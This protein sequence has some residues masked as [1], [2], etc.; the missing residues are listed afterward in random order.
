MKVS[1]L[2]TRLAP[3]MVVA[4]AAGAQG[5][6]A[7]AWPSYSVKLLPAIKTATGATQ[8]THA[9]ALSPS[10][11]A[12]G[13]TVKSA[14]TMRIPKVYESGVGLFPSFS[15]ITGY[16]SIPAFE[17]YPVVW[18]AAGTK[19]LARPDGVYNA[20]GLAMSDD[21]SVLLSVSNKSGKTRSSNGWFDGGTQ[22]IRLWQ[23]G[24]FVTPTYQSQR[25]AAR[26][27]E[28]IG[29]R[30]D[31]GLSGG[32]FVVNPYWADQ[33]NHGPLLLQGSNV[34][35][36]LPGVSNQT[37]NPRDHFV[38][39]LWADGR[40]WISFIPGASASEC[41]FGLPGSMT[42]WQQPEG[43]VNFSCLAMNSAATVFGV[44]ELGPPEPTASGTLRYNER[45]YVI[46]DGGKQ[47]IDVTGV[48]SNAFLDEQERLV[49][50]QSPQY[51]SFDKG[52]TGGMVRVWMSG[53]SRPLTALVKTS[54]GVNKGVDLVDMNERGQLLVQIMR[55]NSLEYAV[56][57]P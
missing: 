5:V 39:G 52:L 45:F 6:Q 27:G 20:I 16:K 12:V 21:G 37:G 23:S 28:F 30:Q 18:S 19:V 47:G 32:R 9:V 44:D 22:H 24:R 56:L 25:I 26:H 53:T 54:L 1:N 43:L 40:G 14:G 29:Y 36:V 4:M 34:T 15:L 10:G 41:Y 17:T 11:D 3:L 8:Q 31:F 57:T 35:E 50:A 55:T 48:V 38:R 46:K 51:G 2:L 7:Q 13:W 49:Y 42:K 33:T